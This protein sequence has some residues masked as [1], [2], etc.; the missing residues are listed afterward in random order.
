MPSNRINSCFDDVVLPVDNVQA[1]QTTRQSP[2]DKA[3]S[4][5][6]F[7][8]FNL[9]LHVG[10]DPSQVSNNRNLLLDFLPSHSQIQWL[11]QVHANNVEIINS[12][13]STPRIADAM[14]TSTPK[15]AL[16][17]MTADCLPILLTNRG[18]NEVG[19][20]HGGW[21]PLA[22]NIIE[23]TLTSMKTKNSDIYAWLGPCIG[24]SEFE[25]GDEVKQAF[26]VGS[27]DL[28]QCFKPKVKGKWLAD[29]K[30]IAI[31]LLKYHGVNIVN[32]NDTCTY[33][34]NQRY[35]S[36]R[37]EKVTGRMASLICIT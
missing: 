33:K 16:A 13:S 35:Y 29:L 4:Q 21:R 23:H 34:N 25:V 28:S 15:V 27:A 31:S 20:I 24:P 11:D 26:A 22:L 17:I 1:L 19:V 18:G 2:A 32:S 10:D 30:G 12:V 37:R 7:N 14:I 6:P 8:S 9:G 36:Y 5:P 3:Q